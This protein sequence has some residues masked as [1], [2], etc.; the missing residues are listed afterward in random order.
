M[1]GTRLRYTVTFANEG[2]EAATNFVATDKLPA[3]TTYVAGIAANPDR[4]RGRRRP[5]RPGQR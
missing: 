5:D 1:P 2:L 3:D 4:A